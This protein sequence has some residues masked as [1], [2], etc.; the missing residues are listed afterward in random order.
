MNSQPNT[1]FSK[2]GMSVKLPPIK[3]ADFLSFEEGCWMIDSWRLDSHHRSIHCSLNYQIR[4]A[5]A[6]GCVLPAPASATPQPPEHS[7]ITK[8]DSLTQPGTTTG[9][10]SAQ[11]C[12]KGRTLEPC[13][14]YPSIAL[15]EWQ[16]SEC[17]ELQ[18]CRHQNNV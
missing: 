10:Y 1:R 8:R 13:R 17:W 5:Y 16:L 14:S 9:T 18:N 4:A 15:L 3:H 6:A 12:G 7:R 2:S 11:T